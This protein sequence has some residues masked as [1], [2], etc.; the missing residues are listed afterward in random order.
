MGVMT[1]LMGRMDGA[2]GDSS[3]RKV[4]NERNPYGK[5]CAGVCAYAVEGEL[6]QAGGK[7][8]RA[9]GELLLELSL[10]LSLELVVVRVAGTTV[11]VVWETSTQD[12]VA[13]VST[14]RCEED[15]AEEESV[16]EVAWP[17]AAAE[18]F[19]REWKVLISVTRLNKQMND[20]IKCCLDVL[21]ASCTR[22]TKI[23]E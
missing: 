7:L 15:G 18:L 16:W 3:G 12:W 23:A 20:V 14:C 4:V 1:G 6:M 21:N 10:E 22:I 9:G 17:M 2:R 11:V 13:T 8:T 5:E 19:H